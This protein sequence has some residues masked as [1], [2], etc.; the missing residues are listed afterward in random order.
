M[1]SN[2]LAHI[3]LYFFVCGTSG[4]TTR[5]VRNICAVVVLTWL[6][7]DQIA[8]HTLSLPFDLMRS[9]TFINV[10]A[11]SRIFCYHLHPTIGEHTFQFPYKGGSLRPGTLFHL[12]R[13]GDA[14]HL[15]VS[16]D[17]HVLP[18]SIF[19]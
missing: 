11:P 14:M 4:Y 3:L 8:I 6:N 19:I 13:V 5:K 17:I 1:Q 10:A 7:D 2:S 9:R 15:S 18:A 12:I 16:C